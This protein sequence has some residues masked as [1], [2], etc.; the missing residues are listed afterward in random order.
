MK[1]LFTLMFVAVLAILA[2]P[3][4][5][6]S[7]DIPI[8]TV[9]QIAYDAAPNAAQTISAGAVCQMPCADIAYTVKSQ[10]MLPE[11]RAVDASN[12]VRL[13]WNPG[14]EIGNRKSWRS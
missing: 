11:P 8:F 2:L 13:L 7:P 14:A 10:T 5:A 12:T 3:A 6:Q 1:K 4:I 9:S